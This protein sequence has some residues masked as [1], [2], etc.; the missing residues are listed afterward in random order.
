ME[1]PVAGLDGLAGWVGGGWGG[2]WGG[3]G[4]DALLTHVE[5]TLNGCP[6]Q[7]VQI[8]PSLS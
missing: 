3:G 2:G 5:L 8:G 1:G 4:G 7:I 6:A